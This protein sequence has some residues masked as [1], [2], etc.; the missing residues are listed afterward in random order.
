MTI[1][2]LSGV[3]GFLLA[4]LIA[5]FLAP[6][7]WRKAVKVTTRRL[8]QQSPRMM[9]DGQADRDQMRAEFAINTA[10]MEAKIEQLKEVSDTQ[11]IEL[12]ST[13][14]KRE[15]LLEKI[16]SLQTTAESQEKLIRNLNRKIQPPEAKTSKKSRTPCAGAE[17]SA[18]QAAE[19]KAQATALEAQ[20]YELDLHKQK[21]SQLTRKLETRKK[22]AADLKQDVGMGRD[23]ISSLIR[24][25]DTKDQEVAQL[26]REIAAQKSLETSPSGEAAQEGNDNK[27]SLVKVSAK[28]PHKP[29][30]PL[31]SI[32][33]SSNTSGSS[34]NG[35][36]PTTRP[37]LCAETG[38]DRPPHPKRRS[39]KKIK[40]VKKPGSLSLAERIRALQA[41]SPKSV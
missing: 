17:P 40:P 23:R 19:L 6:S 20:A 18:K 27:V 41:D 33:I 35:L 21:I 9:S 28:Q 25:I 32:V 38:M 12:S 11:L 37:A 29:A 7:L 31:A 26:T 8:L 14:K 5:L 39:D 13:E 3:L 36:E 2:L 34:S 10:K 4:S 16:K 24:K 1:I 15:R 30:K 22:T